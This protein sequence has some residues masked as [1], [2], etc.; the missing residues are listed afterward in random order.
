MGKRVKLKAGDIFR[1]QSDAGLVGAGQIID[2]GEVFYITI[3]QPALQDPIE[4]NTVPT[5]DILLCGWTTDA[6]F[7]HGKWRVIGNRPVPRDQVP[8]PCSKVQIE[9]RTW[10]QDHRGKP[11]RRAT[12]FE[13]EQ[14]P[15]QSS[16]SPGIYA[17]AF[18]A[19]HGMSEWLPYYDKIT[20]KQAFELAAIC[21]R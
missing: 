15:F 20:A 5:D 13:A 10:I 4:V 16:R 11:F 1:F 7:F 9:G 21:V 2:P 3:L 6:L 12:D 8:K 19:H 18:E 17:D 14:L